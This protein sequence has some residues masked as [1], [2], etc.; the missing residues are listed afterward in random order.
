MCTRFEAF[1]KEIRRIF[2]VSNEKQAAERAVQYL[3]QRTSAAEYAARFQEQANLTKWD[4]AALMIMFRRGLKNVVKDELMKSGAD[5]ENL[6][7]LIAESIRS[8]DMLYDRAME[9]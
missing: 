7:E 3:T 4:D 5:T 1:K 8:D 2:C 9:K 6:K